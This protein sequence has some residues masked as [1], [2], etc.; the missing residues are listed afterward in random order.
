MFIEAIGPRLAAELPGEVRYEARVNE[1]LFRIN[2]DVRFSSDKTPYKNHIDMWFWQGDKKGWET[3]GYFLRL[4]PHQ[5]AIG[6]GMHHLGKESLEAYRAAIVDERRVR[7][8]DKAVAQLEGTGL[9]L[10]G[11]TRK[12]VPR[13]YDAAQPRAHY[14]LHEALFGI[15]YGPVPAQA[16]TPGFVD[17]CLGYFKAASPINGWLTEALQPGHR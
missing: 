9:E 13:G 5:W 11:S 8:L 4:E 2:R 7:T 16:H 10:G 3:P 14:L 6:G 17:L 12:S 15:H 1:S